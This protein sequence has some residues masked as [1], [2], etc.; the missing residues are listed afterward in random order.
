MR[1]SIKG[2]LF[3]G[4]LGASGLGLAVP[5]ATGPAPLSGLRA[6]IYL[7]GIFYELI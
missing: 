1:S 2:F 6:F 5:A 4:L 7:E 3:A